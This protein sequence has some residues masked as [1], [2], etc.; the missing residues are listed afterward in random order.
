MKAYKLYKCRENKALRRKL[1]QYLAYCLKYELLDNLQNDD[2]AYAKK[3][4]N[5]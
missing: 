1:N 5:A 3:L 4:R 2:Y